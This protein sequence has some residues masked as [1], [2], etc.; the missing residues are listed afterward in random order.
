[1]IAALR[2]KSILAGFAGALLCCCG[3]DRSRQAPQIEPTIESDRSSPPMAPA[4]P[5]LTPDASRESNSDAAQPTRPESDRS[6]ANPST[7]TPSESIPLD[8]AREAPDPT[9]QP[10]RD[11]P[12]PHPPPSGPSDS[13]AAFRLFLPTTRGP[14][15]VDV[16]ISIEGCDL[17][18]A[19][20]DQIDSVIREATVTGAPSWT[21][22]LEHVQANPQRF[23]PLPADPSG[24]RNLI[25]T[26]DRNRNG[27]VELDEVVPF[28]FR[29]GRHHGPFRLVG[30][31][32]FRGVNRIES[33]IFRSLDR[34]ANQQLEPDEIEQAA[35]SLRRLDHN[36][37]HRIDWIEIDAQLRNRNDNPWDARRAKRWG[38]VAMDLSGFVDWSML[39]YSL[40][41]MP[42]QGV[43]HDGP[44]ALAALDQNLN[45]SIDQEEAKGLLATPADLR[46]TI[47]YDAFAT[48]PP[49]I[50]AQLLAG[51]NAG[52]VVLSNAGSSV[53]IVGEDLILVV[54]A[55]D[56]IRNN[57]FPIQVFTQL[58]SDQDG[59]LVESE[60]P[61]GVLRDRSFEELDQNHDG[62]LTASELREG[63]AE[64]LPVWSLQVR[65]RG[66]EAPDALFVWL[67]EDQD[68][69]LSA[70]ELNRCGPRIHERRNHAGAVVPND[71]PDT[72]LLQ[73][74]RGNPQ[75][76]DAIFSLTSP[77]QTATPVR[78]KWAESMDRNQDGDISRSEF[79]GSSQ[80]F[81]ALDQN[82][83]QFL[84]PDELLLEPGGAD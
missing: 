15:L 47:Q 37:D 34:N 75:Q 12:S 79:L 26:H 17:S 76:E 14:L 57:N 21:K 70:R 9:A 24:S 45:E 18:Q 38:N 63:I 42:N 33:P 69:S 36:G 65:G 11:I 27:R 25:D 48:S 1:M 22:L 60:I 6:A 78:P 62:K 56:L 59:V 50:A 31:D 54:S 51:E 7:A 4:A 82:G 80:Q 74:G 83:D 52:L 29:D 43:F 23:G 16:D 10:L 61:S 39:S 68:R 53:R 20:E 30:S 13:P 32:A 19:L 64:Q 84:E 58:D 77:R 46:L 41:G 67:D 2:R 44:G 3:C 81:D 71:F 5:H 40:E 72:F 28:L 8:N 73:F 35:T 66:A 55:T 49:Q